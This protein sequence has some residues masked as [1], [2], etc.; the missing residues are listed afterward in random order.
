MISLI[1]KFVGGALVGVY[2][3]LSLYACIP[4]RII[5]GEQGLH[6]LASVRGRGGGAE[7]IG[8]AS[9]FPALALGVFIQVRNILV[10]AAAAGAGACQGPSSIP[11]PIRAPRVSWLVPDRGIVSLRSTPCQ[12]VVPLIPISQ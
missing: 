4:T 12:K 7:R 6:E 5:L 2:F 10:I 3:G 8:V 9:G 1:G 11:F